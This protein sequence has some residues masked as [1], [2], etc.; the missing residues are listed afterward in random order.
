MRSPWQVLR[1]SGAAE[2]RRERV[3]LVQ[4]SLDF[5]SN[6]VEALNKRTLPSA[7]NP[8][9]VDEAANFQSSNEQTICNLLFGFFERLSLHKESFIWSVRLGTSVSHSND[10]RRQKF[11]AG[12]R[13]Q[14][15]IEDPFDPTD[16]VARDISKSM[17]NLIKSA[18]SRAV[19]ILQLDCPHRG[20]SSS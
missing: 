16:N 13:I 11:Q 14:L 10:R 18:A 19:K 3:G 20:C 6:L 4:G 15:C 1:V 5:G 8:F 2:P 12:H 9:W 7:G 17:L